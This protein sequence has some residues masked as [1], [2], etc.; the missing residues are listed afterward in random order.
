[1]SF[2]PSGDRCFCF[3]RVCFFREKAGYDLHNLASN[4][5][6]NVSFQLYLVQWMQAIKAFAPQCTP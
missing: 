3:G 4:F 5:R 1:M 6:L 2:D